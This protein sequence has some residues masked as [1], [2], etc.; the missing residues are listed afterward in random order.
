TE[1][2]VNALYHGANDYIKK[3]LDIPELIARV[4]RQLNPLLKK[5]TEADNIY[6]F[7]NLKIDLND[8]K[9][10]LDNKNIHL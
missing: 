9:V 10:G 4:K 6:T 3:T 5:Q 2:V 7:A 1:E 8:H